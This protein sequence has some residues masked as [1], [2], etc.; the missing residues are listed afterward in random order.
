MTDGGGLRIVAEV[1]IPVRFCLVTRT[2]DGPISTAV[3]HPHAQA[4]CRDWLANHLPGV[5]VVPSASTAAA[6]RAVAGGEFDAAICA[7]RAA[8]EYGLHVRAMGIE[9]NPDAQTRFILVAPPGP[10]SAPTGADKTTLELF[11][12][13]DHPGALLEILTEFSVRGVNLTRI[14]SRPTK[15]TLGS[16][17]FSVDCEGHVADARVG[18]ALM[19]LAPHLFRRP[20]P[21][22]LPAARPARAGDPAGHDESGLRRGAGVAV[23][24]PRQLNAQRRSSSSSRCATRRG[25]WPAAPDRRATAPAD[26]RW[27][28]R[29]SGPPPPASAGR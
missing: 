20:V 8:I 17:F 14:E 26:G 21:R 24:N 10:P 23:G 16:Y 2:P 7:E 22:L 6:A 18:E 12:H 4:Q 13:A 27:P 19:G 1:A 5:D 28:P 29:R 15:T 11:M 3:T 25:R 9:D